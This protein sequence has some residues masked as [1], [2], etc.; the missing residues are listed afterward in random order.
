MSENGKAAVVEEL[1]PSAAAGP[2]GWGL[3]AHFVMA[4]AT[5]GLWGYAMLVG[6]IL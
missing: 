4:V 2:C 3:A 5:G 1:E 6:C